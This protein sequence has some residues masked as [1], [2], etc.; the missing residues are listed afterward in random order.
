MGVVT[1]PAEP[2]ERLRRASAWR[3]FPSTRWS[4]IILVVVYLPMALTYSLLTRE[5]EADDEPAH[6]QYI[7]YIVGHHALPHIAVANGLE[8][9]QPPLYYLLEAGWQEVLGIPAFTPVVVP[10]PSSKALFTDRL[11]Y[12]TDYTPSEH[13]DA[14][15]VHE[16]RL[17]SVVFGLGTVLLTYA[18]AKIIGLRELWALSC[19]LF[20]ALWPKALIAAS[21]VSNDALV[22]PLCVLALVLFLLSER[23]GTQGRLGRRRIDLVAMG[24]V[25]GAAA[26][27]KFNSL[28]IAVVLFALA[29][30]SSLAGMGQGN[31]H[32]RIQLRM[33]L[34]VV[35]AVVAFFVLSAWW[36]VRNHHLYGQFLATDAS[37]KYLSVFLLHPVPLNTHLLFSVYPNTLLNFSWYDQPNFLLP[38][39][40]SEA[41]AVLAVPCLLV[42][43]WAVVRQRRWVS[44]VLSPLSALSLLGCIVAGFLAMLIIIKDTSLGN[45][46]DAFVALAAIAIV[47]TVGSVRILSRISPRLE[48]VGVALWPIVLLSLDLYV[49]IRFLIPLGGL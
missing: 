38:A 31:R 20:P 12:S 17:L 47:I 13:A 46:R 35:L 1:R 4:L 3:A 10:A 9:H 26:V 42:G 16:L 24:L 23:A 15:H 44:R 43:A 49:V 18:A 41:L 25:F 34:D 28:P 8:S 37:E 19:G 32:P 11:V 2:V 30:V 27:T 33:F 7:E 36:F 6:V 39:R 29:L 22:T 14:V 21:S 5:Y 48:L 45:T 40:I